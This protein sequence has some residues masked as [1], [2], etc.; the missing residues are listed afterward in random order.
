MIKG[1]YLDEGNE[2]DITV[3]EAIKVL[4]NDPGINMYIQAFLHIY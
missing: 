1:A 2:I 3:A 4:W